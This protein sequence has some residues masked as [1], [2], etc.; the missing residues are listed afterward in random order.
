MTTMS[1]ERNKTKQSKN[2]KSKKL[3]MIGK[4][5]LL[6]FKAT[7]TAT[8]STVLALDISIPAITNFTRG[9]GKGIRI[10]QEDVP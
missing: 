2:G 3:N 1:Y 9:N 5:K 4:F 8:H 6:L 10:A 7:E